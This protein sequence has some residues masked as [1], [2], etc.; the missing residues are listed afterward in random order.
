VADCPEEL[1]H[2]ID[3]RAIRLEELDIPEEK[4]DLALLSWSL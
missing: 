1:R 3:F 4:F 2:K